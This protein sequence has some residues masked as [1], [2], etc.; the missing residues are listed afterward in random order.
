MLHQK[1]HRRST[2]RRR[3]L[4]TSRVSVRATGI[5]SRA[6]QW[7]P[8]EAPFRAWDGALGQRVPLDA[9]PGRGAAPRVAGIQ[10]PSGIGRSGSRP[11]PNQVRKG[12]LATFSARSFRTA[13]WKGP[14]GQQRAPR[15]K[16]RGPS[17]LAICQ[18]Q[19][20][21]VSACAW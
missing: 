17:P 6:P 5:Q 15:P 9:T 4:G 10:A 18:C 21:W 14:A 8:G 11:K 1:R 20:A 13:R 19:W 7:R 3:G 16:V 2:E 12:V